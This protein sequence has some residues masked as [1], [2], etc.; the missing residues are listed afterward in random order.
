MAVRTRESEI[1]RVAR[2]AQERGMSYGKFVA[3][4]L[5]APE[6]TRR[7]VRREPQKDEKRCAYAQCGKM[8][9]ADNPRTKYC[10][11]TCRAKQMMENQKRREI[12][13]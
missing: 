2:A 10:C 13:E 3:L 4:G 6:E 1:E 12:D 5:E 9:Y 11:T 8:F 7:D